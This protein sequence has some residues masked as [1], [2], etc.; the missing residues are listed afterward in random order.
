MYK[1][2]VLKSHFPKD[3]R[4]Y[5]LVSFSCIYLINVGAFILGGPGLSFPPYKKISHQRPRF[6]S[7]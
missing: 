3:P 5:E 1:S 7:I 4:L 2:F 6:I